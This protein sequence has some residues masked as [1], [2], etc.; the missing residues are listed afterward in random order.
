M[1]QRRATVGPVEVE[2]I[3]DAL[4][5]TLRVA[6][7]AAHV[8]PMSAP[9]FRP[10]PGLERERPD[11][12]LLRL[13][14]HVPFCSYACSFC[15]YAKRIGAG[16][17]QMERYVRALERELEWIEPGVRLPQLYVGGGTPTVLPPDL[18]D[19]VL[20][21]LFARM[22]PEGPEAHTVESSPESIT[23]AHLD[24]LR[25]HGID[26]VSMGIQ[27][28]DRQVLDAIHRRHT[29]EAALAAVDLLV[30]S[31]LITG[32]DFIYGLP[33]Q[34]EDSFR[35]DLEAVATRG[36]DSLTLY[37]L[38]LNEMTPLAASLGD[39]ERLDLE[40]LV[41]WR[42]FVQEVTAELGFVQ[43][44]WH[45]FKRPSERAL[46]YE[47]A[48]CIDGFGSGYQ[49]GVGVSAVSHLGDTVYRNE[50]GLG[51]YVERI[52][53]GE[54]PVSGVFPLGVA[55]RK[56]LFIVRSLGD[57]HALDRACYAASFG[58]SF[59]EEHGALIACLRDAGLVEDDGDLLAL[60]DLG[61]LVYDLVTLAFYPRDARTWLAE[62]QTLDR[63]RG[64]AATA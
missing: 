7:E 33:A 52:E 58:V 28:M 48:P 22:R 19:E 6:Y 9:A 27:S 46:R 56:T 15:F 14:V 32:V 3:R 35:R 18:L 40:R 8:Y 12:A 51:A 62:H 57:G 13:Y 39:L 29:P 45:T 54:S 34:T 20:T 30:D 16:R 49:L 11:Q 10:S 42:A 5:P 2:L 55:D 43:T 25:R 21:A 50:E 63:S 61:K 1:T 44:R 23:Q 47:R 38:R 17:E 59:D 53:S 4:G 41:R 37:D 60:S 24:V 36:I 26:R 64:S 31:G